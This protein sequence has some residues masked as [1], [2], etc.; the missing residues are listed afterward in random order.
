[1]AKTIT[2]AHF[3]GGTGKTT[4]CISV[5][6]FL[7]KKGNKVLAIDL[8]PQANLT[9]GLGI[10][11]SSLEGTI[12]HVMSG[13]SDIR[14][15]I[16]KTATENLHVAPSHPSLIGSNLKSYKSKKDGK[17][18]RNALKSV[19]KFYDYILID[20]PPSNGH[21]IVNGVAASNSVV[22]CLDPGIYALEGIETFNK[23][24]KQYCSRLGVKLNVSMALLT[25]TRNA[26]LPFMKN[27]DEQIRQEAADL[28]GLN[29]VPVPFSDHIYESQVKGVPISHLK[30]NSTVGK[31]YNEI[32]EKVR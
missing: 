12:S 6:G 19:N 25:K 9:S 7:A 17:I 22:L 15:V 3:K 29:V 10:D 20:T 14:N 4:S 18:L 24:L 21:F 32:S 30:P 11:R 5:A 2:F 16:L 28:L 31:A 1:V 13:K 8:D 23:S 26:I 27:K